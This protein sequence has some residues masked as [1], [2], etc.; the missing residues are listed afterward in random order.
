MAPAPRP[1]F[2]RIS[3]AHHPEDRGALASGHLYQL[4][5]S[6]WDGLGVCLGSKVGHFNLS[7]LVTLLP[8]KLVVLQKIGLSGADPGGSC[9]EDILEMMFT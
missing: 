2:H 9:V 5:G 7:F 1:D 3:G 8:P 4:L 6:R